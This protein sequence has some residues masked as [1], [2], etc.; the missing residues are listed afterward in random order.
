MAQPWPLAFE[1]L[2]IGRAWREIARQYVSAAIPIALCPLVLAQT[3]TE[4]DSTDDDGGE[5]A[6]DESEEDEEED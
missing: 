2:S 6:D 5:A 4:A 1:Q 3:E